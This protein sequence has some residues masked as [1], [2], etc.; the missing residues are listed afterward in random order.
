MFAA[1]LRDTCGRLLEGLHA[2]AVPADP[3]SFTGAAYHTEGLCG[4]V[5]EALH[6]H[7]RSNEE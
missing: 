2:F 4:K 3:R 6:C 1:S 7:V 5:A